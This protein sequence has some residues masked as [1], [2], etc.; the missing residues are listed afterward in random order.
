MSTE[1]SNSNCLFNSSVDS[2]FPWSPKSFQLKQGKMFYID[3]GQGEP[4]IFIHGN[5][6]WSFIYR[7]FIAE[8]SQQ[9]RTIAPDHLGFGRSEKPENADYSLDWHILNLTQFLSQLDLSSVTMILH[10]WGGPIG[11]GW[12]TQNPEK[13]KR[14]ILLNTWAFVSA[15]QIEL[16]EPLQSIK[17]SGLGEKL[18]IDHNVMV[19]KGILEGICRRDTLNPKIME[20]YRAPFKNPS[21]RQSILKLVREIPTDITDGAAITIKTIQNNLKK[22]RLP[23]L[24]IWGEQDPVFPTEILTMWRLYFP[25]AT[26]HILKNASH[27]LQ[28]DCPEEIIKY[29]RSFL[30]NNP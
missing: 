27:F 11:L 19:E 16:P 7:K 14:L 30:E 24:I 6:T 8:F 20:S 5:P 2:A 23:C 9:Y 29:I 17:K 10:D 18:V 3:E 4:L 13:I 28:E 1:T 21:D 22:L 26:C 25:Q 15:N 12:A